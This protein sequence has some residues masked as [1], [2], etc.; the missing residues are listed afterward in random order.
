MIALQ[1]LA[2][3]CI[4]AWVA[5]VYLMVLIGKANRRR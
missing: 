4:V 2:G 1:I 3:V 5:V